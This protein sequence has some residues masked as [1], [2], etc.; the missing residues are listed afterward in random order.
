M[1][2][3]NF[4]TTATLL[5]LLAACSQSNEKKIAKDKEDYQEATRQLEKKERTHPSQ[6]LSLNYRDKHNMLGQTVVR[7]TLSNSAKICTFQ[8]VQLALS[9][10]SKTGTLLL[11]TSETVYETVAPGNSVKFKSKE[12]APKGSDSVVIKVITAVVNK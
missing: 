4:I 8:D 1:K 12:F 3:S 5:L 7:G 11:T 6:F 9:Y 10:Y 2:L